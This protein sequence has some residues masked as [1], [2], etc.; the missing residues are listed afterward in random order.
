MDFSNH[1]DPDTFNFREHPEHYRIGKGEEGVFRFEPYRTELLPLLNYQNAASAA[2][3]AK[4]LFAKF[5]NYLDAD[6]F[7]GADMARKYLQMGFSR[8]LR[9]ASINFTDKLEQNSAQDPSAI[10]YELY[11]QALKHPRYQSL[12]E[13]HEENYG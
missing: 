7:P 6:D 13:K 11:Q 9:H 1:N 2:D 10:F 8:S 3:S 12:R 5:L 4:I